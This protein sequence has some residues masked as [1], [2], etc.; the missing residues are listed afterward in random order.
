MLRSSDEPTQRWFFSSLIPSKGQNNFVTTSLYQTLFPSP[1]Q[2]DLVSR[3][4]RFKLLNKGSTLYTD[5][6]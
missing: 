5:H 4:R 2:P 6:R 3:M 1:T